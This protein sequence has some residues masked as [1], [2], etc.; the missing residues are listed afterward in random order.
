MHYYDR[1]NFITNEILQK[2]TYY[3]QAFSTKIF[4]EYIL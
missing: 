3:W 2:Y 4:Y 1:I